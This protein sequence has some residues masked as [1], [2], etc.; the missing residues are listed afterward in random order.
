MGAPETG[1]FRTESGV[2]LEM[3][4]PLPEAIAQRVAR[5]DIVR[6][7]PMRVPKGKPE[8]W[9]PYEPP[10]MDPTPD[11]ADELAAA[12]AHVA[13][14][15]KRLAEVAAERDELKAKAGNIN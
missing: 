5:G 4:L 1:H 13:D 3:D 9:A 11:P 10:T 14:L 8:R 7:T 15:E 2:V 6:V 12:L